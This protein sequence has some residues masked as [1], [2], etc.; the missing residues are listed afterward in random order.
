MKPPGL[1]NIKTAISVVIC[2]A[3]IK[4][5]NMFLGDYQITY[6]YAGITAVFTLSSSMSVSFQ[7]GKGR[8]SGTIIGSLVGLFYGIIRLYVF[9]GG[10]ELILLF[11]AIVTCIYIINNFNHEHGFMIGGIMVIASFTTQQDGFII[12]MILR[13]LQ[14]I[15]GVGVALFV[16]RF[17][18]PYKEAS[19]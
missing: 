4:I 2:A 10:I 16:N 11:L 8:I 7:R 13:T 5:L 18:F 17:I 1:R 19:I 14:T 9:D 12:Y 15:Y 6:F 3:S